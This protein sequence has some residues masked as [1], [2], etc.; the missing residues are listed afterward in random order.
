MALR[1]FIDAVEGNE[2]TVVEY[3]S[4]PSPELGDLF[5]TRNVTVV[6]RTLPDDG[7]R[8][9]VV[10]RR[11]SE[12]CGFWTYDPDTVGEVVAYLCENY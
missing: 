5:E 11:D 8:G 10:V 12:F 4:T 7:S 6:H 2:Q 1:D 3:S 9:F